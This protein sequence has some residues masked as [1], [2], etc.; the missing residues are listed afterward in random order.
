VIYFLF[1]AGSSRILA[2]KGQD[3]R[4]VEV[5]EVVDVVE[6]VEV[7]VVCG[8]RPELPPS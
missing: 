3:E 2:A 4:M 5:V 8:C 6:V 7:V 1:L